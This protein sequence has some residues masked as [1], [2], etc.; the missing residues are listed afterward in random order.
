MLCYNNTVSPQLQLN[1]TSKLAF[2]ETVD[3]E[4]YFRPK[5]NSLNNEML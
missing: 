1:E 4:V 2:D 5:D 3:F